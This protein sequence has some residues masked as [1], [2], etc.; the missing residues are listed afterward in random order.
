MKIILLTI[1]LPTL[2]LFFFLNLAAREWFL[3][4]QEKRRRAEREEALAESLGLIS[5]ASRKL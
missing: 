4:I 2:I 3:R 5:P 1:I